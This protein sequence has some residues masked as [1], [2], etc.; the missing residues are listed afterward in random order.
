MVKIQVR[1]EPDGW[2]AIIVRGKQIM[3][4]DK[5]FDG[6]EEAFLEAAASV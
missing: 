3:V 4:L 1:K 5:T 2:R 6:E